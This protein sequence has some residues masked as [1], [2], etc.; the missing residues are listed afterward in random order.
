M[1]SK[2]ADLCSGIILQY[3]PENQIKFRLRFM[4]HIGFVKRTGWG[5]IGQGTFGKATTYTI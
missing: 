1:P 5:R 4:M 2:L 3:A